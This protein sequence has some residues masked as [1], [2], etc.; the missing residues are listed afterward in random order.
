VLAVKE[1]IRIGID[2]SNGTLC[3]FHTTSRAGVMPE[4]NRDLRERWINVLGEAVPPSW[5]AP[6]WRTA[7]MPSLLACAVLSHFPS[8]DEGSICNSSIWSSTT[9]V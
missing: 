6:H 7:R 3:C 5:A 1:N 9:Y 8:L 4:V 2:F